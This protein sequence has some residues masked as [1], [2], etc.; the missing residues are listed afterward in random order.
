MSSGWS[1]ITS[2]VIC[3]IQVIRGVAKDSC[4]FLADG[5]LQRLNTTLYIELM[6]YS[7]ECD[8]SMGFKSSY[9][10]RLPSLMH[11]FG[12]RLTHFEPISLLN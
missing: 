10:A 11:S 1:R 8:S 12:V 2:I 5:A 6:L 4:R 9:T 3:M 7:F